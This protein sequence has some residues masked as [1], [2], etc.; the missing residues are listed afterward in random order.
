MFYLMVQKQ[1]FKLYFSNVLFPVTL[2]LSAASPSDVS[3]HPDS[4][5]VLEGEQVEL[6]CS[7]EGI[8]PPLFQ[9]NGLTVERKMFPR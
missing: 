1:Q 5:S 6:T 9:V 7:A 8:P 4:L 2:S 3:I